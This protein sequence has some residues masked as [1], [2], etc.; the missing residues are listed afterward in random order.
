[1]TYGAV[2]LVVKLLLVGMKDLRD[3]ADFPDFVKYLLISTKQIPGIS[4]Y[5]TTIEWVKSYSYDLRSCRNMKPQTRGSWTR[6]II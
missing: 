1:M 3:S 6:A 4:I 5:R 2:Q